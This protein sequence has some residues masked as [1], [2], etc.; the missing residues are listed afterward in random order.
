MFR[1]LPCFLFAALTLAIAVPNVHAETQ[2]RGGW[3]TSAPREE[4]RPT[5]DLLETGGHDGKAVLSITAE[6]PGTGERLAG[7]VGHWQKKVAVQG[8]QHYRFSVWRQTH[9]IDLIRRAAM[10]RVVWLDKDGRRPQRDEVSSSRLPAKKPR[11]EPEFPVDAETQGDWTRLAGLYRAPSTATH[12]VLELHFRWGPPG[13]SVWWSDP[14]LTESEPAEPR[15]VR[16]ATVHYRPQTGTTNRDK[17]ELF[18][19]LIADAARQR[20]DLVVLPETLTYYGKGGTYADSAETIPGPSTEYFGKLAKQH[21]LYI[22]AGLLERDGHLVYNTA[23]LIGPQGELVGKYRKVTLPRG[24]IEGGIMPGQDYPVFDTRFG[25]VGIMICYDGFFP[26]VARELSN[27]GAEVIAW[28]VWGCNP[29]LGAA[30][31]CENHT[32]VISSTYTDVSSAWMISA[33]YGHH[34]K[35]LASATEWGSVAVAEVDLNK[36]MHWASLGDFKAQV[37]RHRPVTTPDDGT[38]VKA[39]S[40]DRGG[41]Q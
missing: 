11:S 33:I 32:Y 5:F 1:R 35:P 6:N 13:S 28:P 2:R 34:G 3:E 21:D 40:P 20:A 19:P 4:I 29:M 25:K 39:E 36:P 9:G 24:E 30:R 10:A 23:A 38:P 37:P 27:R 22:V 16:L 18:A 7:L 31:A 15:I 8:G 12:A 17:C 14:K 26:E 41:P